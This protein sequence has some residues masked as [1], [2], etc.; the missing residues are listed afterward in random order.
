MLC[1]TVTSASPQSTTTS[2]ESK[3]FEIISVQGNDLVVKTEE[4][5]RELTVPEDFRLTVDGQPMTVQELKPGM[6]GTAT[7]TTRTRMTP[8][9]VT[10]VKEGT[11]IRKNAT[12]IVVETDQGLRSFALSDLEK[13]GITIVR[14]GRPAQISDLR[15]GDKL[16]ATIIT[17]LPPAVVSQREVQADIEQAAKEPAATPSPAPVGTTGAAQEP[18]P[19]ELPR[20]AGP[21]P[22]IGLL[23]LTSLVV[24]AAL[25]ARRRRQAR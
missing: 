15:E 24:G 10:E 12:E 4:G 20:T 19:Q 18:A 9:T 14:D 3:K 13:R 25:A 7:I 2:T 6:V 21:L 1:L 22:I 5:T 17:T 11:V 8:V 23:G 16:T